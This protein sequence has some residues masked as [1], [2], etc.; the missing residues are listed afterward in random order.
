MFEL[1]FQPVKSRTGPISV[2]CAA[3]A[4]SATL[5]LNIARNFTAETQRTRRVRGESGLIIGF[6]A[7]ILLPIIGNGQTAATCA[8]LNNLVKATY[9]FKPSK[10]SE[11][12]KNAK[13]AEMDRVWDMVKANRTVL[14]PCLRAAIESR[15][16]D[17][18]FKF[19]GSNLLVSLDPSA[20]SKALQVATYTQVD[21]NDVSLRIWVTTLAQRATEGFDISEA[22]V[23]WLNHPNARYALPA[24]GAFQVRR[25]EGALILFGSMDE[26]HATPALLRVL[27]QSAGEVRQIALLL[28]MGQATPEALRALKQMDVSGFPLAVQRA[29][30]KRLTNPDVVTPR[31]TPKTTRQEFLQAFQRFVDGNPSDFMRLVA[32]VPDGERD[33]VAVLRPEDI[34][35]VRKVRRKFVSNGN[36]H[37]LQFYT[38]FTQILMTMVWK[39]GL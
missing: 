38:G 17:Q 1:L 11:P 25:L 19:D 22:G 6:F 2:L 12:E 31:L 8:Q 35:L 14:L 36:Q 3:S 10:L 23:R 7:V 34:P 21:L 20:S 4:L 15:G 16:A 13:S 29:L 18:W 5:R 26:T 39:P 9:T 24:H 27:Q 32:Q 33:V 30:Q 28:L 37:G